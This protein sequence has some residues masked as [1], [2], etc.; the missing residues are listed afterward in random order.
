VKKCPHCGFD[1][2]DNNWSCTN[3]GDP[4]P[5]E[6]IPSENKK[7]RTQ[8][9]VDLSSSIGSDISKMMG[10]LKD[11]SKGIKDGSLMVEESADFEFSTAVK[12]WYIICI[13]FSA[14]SAFSSFGIVFSTTYWEYNTAYAF[15][16]LISVILMVILCASYIW[17]LVKKTKLAFF[18]MLVVSLIALILGLVIT[19]SINWGSIIAPIIHFL[20]LRKYW[21]NMISTTGFKKN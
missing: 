4:F 6:T 13:V 12:A 17:L 9:A 2:D 10:D 5:L 20:I 19:Q 16:G 8:S 14:F 15:Y 11:T 3:C 21:D 7:T 18:T 1:N